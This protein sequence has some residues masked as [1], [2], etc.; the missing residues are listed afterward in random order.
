M[1]TQVADYQDFYEIIKRTFG[2]PKPRGNVYWKPLHC[3]WCG[4]EGCYKQNHKE[5]DYNEEMR[6]AG[7]PDL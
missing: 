6:E 5:Y 1:L 4:L 7:H 2:K 3:Q